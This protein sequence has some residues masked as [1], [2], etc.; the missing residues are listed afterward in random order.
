MYA[1]L[2]VNPRNKVGGKQCRAHAAGG[3]EDG[4]VGRRCKRIA[5]PL[6]P[7]PGIV[8]TCH[9]NEEGVR[10]GIVS[11]RPLAAALTT[12]LLAL[13]S[14]LRDGISFPPLSRGHTTFIELPMDYLEWEDEGAGSCKQP[15]LG[16]WG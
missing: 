10:M 12:V 11:S 9:P 2:K 3:L 6:H 4:G 15:P 1:M 14:A 7:Q 5:A 13:R 16:R 8:P